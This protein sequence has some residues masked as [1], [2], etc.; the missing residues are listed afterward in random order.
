MLNKNF[1]NSIL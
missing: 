1:T